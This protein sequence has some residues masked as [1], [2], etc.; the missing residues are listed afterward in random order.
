MV[1]LSPSFPQGTLLIDHHQFWHPSMVGWAESFPHWST[2]KVCPDGTHGQSTS[3]MSTNKVTSYSAAKSWAVR[4]LVYVRYFHTLSLGDNTSFV[5]LFW[6]Q[7]AG[8]HPILAD[9]NA[10]AG[11]GWKPGCWMQVAECPH[12]MIPTL[13]TK[14]VVVHFTSPFPGRW[15]LH[16]ANSKCGLK[17]LQWPLSLIKV[18]FI[19]QWM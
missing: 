7:M 6:S 9:G 10:R 11:F 14:F 19:S 1:G 5:W 16:W 17:T 12:T 15:L 8:S 18:I 4:C 2:D 13:G 3:R